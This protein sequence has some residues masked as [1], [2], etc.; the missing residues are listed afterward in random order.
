[1]TG[2]LSMLFIVT[3]EESVLADGAGWLDVAVKLLY[4]P[5]DA[6]LGLLDGLWPQPN[7]RYV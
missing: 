4:R 3:S 2:P 5:C 6:V 7:A 1:V